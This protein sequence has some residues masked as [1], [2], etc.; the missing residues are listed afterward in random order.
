M[1][2]HKTD[3]CVLRI[4]HSIHTDLFTE[5]KWENIIKLI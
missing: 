4:R 2:S 1:I 3:N 5:N